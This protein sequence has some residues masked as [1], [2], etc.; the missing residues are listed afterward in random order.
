[1]PFA[2]EDLDMG[3]LRT[4]AQEAIVLMGGYC[5]GWK[6]FWDSNPE[7][8]CL[9]LKIEQVAVKPYLGRVR[10]VVPR[11]CMLYPDVCLTT[12]GSSRKKTSV[13]VVEKC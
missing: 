13:R 5:F 2:A 7:W 9:E 12:E 4:I 1:M 8:S 11:L 10:A 6:A 3:K